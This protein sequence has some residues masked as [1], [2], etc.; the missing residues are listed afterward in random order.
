MSYYGC[1]DLRGELKAAGFELQPYPAGSRDSGCN[2]QAWRHVESTRECEHNVGKRKCLVVK[3][4]DAYGYK[5]AEVEMRGA[6]GGVWYMLSAYAM[7]DNEVI[8]KL[9]AIE[10]ALVR[11]WEAL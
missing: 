2:W 4:T 10:A 7:R 9:P 11:A 5:S 8:E 1:N 3:P 6:R